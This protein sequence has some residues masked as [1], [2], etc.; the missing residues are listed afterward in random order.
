MPAAAA[1]A[2]D[3]DVVRPLL[4]QRTDM[5]RWVRGILTRLGGEAAA[6]NAAFLMATADGLLLHR[7]TVDPDAAIAEVVGRA[8]DASLAP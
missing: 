1:S 7:L 3:A 2:P 6:R 8:V 4:E 5:E